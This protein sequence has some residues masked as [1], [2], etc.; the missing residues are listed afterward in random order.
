MAPEIQGA[1]NISL[2]PKKNKWENQNLKNMK[3]TPG[4]I[5]ISCICSINDDHSFGPFLPFYPLNKPQNQNFEKMKK[6]LEILS[7][8]ACVP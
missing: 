7:F 4:Y 3:K 6:C 8:Y 2:P 1:T 5:I